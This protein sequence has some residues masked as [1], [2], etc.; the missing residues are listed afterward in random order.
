MLGLAVERREPLVTRRRGACEKICRRRGRGRHSPSGAR[1]GLGTR[2]N[3]TTAHRGAPVAG[4]KGKGPTSRP[5]LSRQPLAAATKRGS[6]VCAKVMSALANSSGSS[7]LSMD[8]IDWKPSSVMTP[9]GE[10][11]GR[12]FSKAVL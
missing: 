1:G 7:V 10:Y 3:G 6:K 9:S 12:A 11:I 4:R 8:S 2:R 5:V